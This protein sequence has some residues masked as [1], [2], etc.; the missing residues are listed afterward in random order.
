MCGLH[1]YLDFI[2]YF[3]FILISFDCVSSDASSL[4]CGLHVFIWIT[5]IFCTSFFYCLSHSQNPSDASPCVWVAFHL[6]FIMYFISFY[7]ISSDA[8]PFGCVACTICS[9]IFTLECSP[10]SSMSQHISSNH[11]IIKRECG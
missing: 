11:Q 7:C 10:P 2:R 5:Y 4:V 1:I 8:S 6:D 9:G 3:V